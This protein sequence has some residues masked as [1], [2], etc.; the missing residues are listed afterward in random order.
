MK[1]ALAIVLF[2]TAAGAAAPGCFWVTTKSEG[3]SLRHDVNDLSGRVSTKEQEVSG[4]VDE[5]QKALDSAKKLLASN[6]AGIGADV[7]RIDEAQRTALGLI[8]A[9]Q[10]DAEDVRTALENYK[11]ANEERLAA[12]EV[13]VAALENP[14]KA[15]P[16]VS[17]DDLWAKAKASFDAGKWS[18]ARDAFKQLTLGFP[19]DQHADDAQYFRGETYFNEK[20][21]DSAIGEY[22]KV[23]D[24]F[25]DSELAD[26]ALYRAGEA[27]VAMKACTEARAYF[28]LVKEKYPKSSLVK[29]AGEQDKQLKKDASNKK[30]CES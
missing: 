25:P 8:T 1:R 26:D 15:T 9:A 16:A 13:R 19:N 29:K 23:F 30:K 27:A 22:Q 17:A 12:L 21:Y 18:D 14:K 11:A 2:F 24:K 28:G 4:K 20:N 3:K 6:S 10:Q 5:L 7:S